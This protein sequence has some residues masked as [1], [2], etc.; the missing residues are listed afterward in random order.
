M[1][2]E[3]SDNRPKAT[4]DQTSQVTAVERRAQLTALRT[5]RDEVIARLSD[6]FARDLIDMDEF[7]RR[8]TSA[9]TSESLDELKG[10]VSDLEP[11]SGLENAPAV[12]ALTNPSPGGV[13]TAASAPD[14]RTLVA[15]FGG[16]DRRGTWTVPRHTKVVAVMGGARIDLRDARFPPGPVD[17]E[18]FA[19]MGGVEIL[20][21]PGLPIE[22][23]G[24]AIMGGFT[25][26]DRTPAQPDPD[27][28][29]LRVHGVVMMGGV[30]VQMRLPG[31]DDGQAAR[32][33]RQQLRQARQRLRQDE[34]AARQLD[35]RR[36]G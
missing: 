5:R 17:I 22:T 26:V 25:E 18:V 12:V 19:M 3:P 9:H 14:R 21:P 28:P 36:G 32:R 34:R 31:E 30:D 27:A 11:A 7:E 16:V 2:S 1:S 29:L 13:A 4:P 6:L 10:L 35:R 15:I 8:V 20:V 23:H 24:T 33:Q